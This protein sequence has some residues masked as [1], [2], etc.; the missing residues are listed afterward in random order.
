MPAK[1]TLKVEGVE[2]PVSNLQKVLYP[3]VGFTKGDLIDYYIRISPVML[4]HL[5]ARAITLKRYPEGVEGFFFYEK[6]C[7]S[8]R[9]KWLQTTDVDRSDGTEI[10]YCVVSSLPAL[11]WTVNLA[12]LEFHAFLHHAKS[13]NKPAVIAFDLDPGPP[14][15]ILDCCK[16]GLLVKRLFDAMGLQSFA[17]TS[18]SK[19]LQVYVPLNTPATYAKT[20]PFAQSVAQLLEQQYPDLVVSKMLKKLRVGKVLVDWSQNDD[21]KTTVNAYSTRAKEHPTVSTPVTWDEVETALKKKKPALLTFET[22]D[23]LKRVETLGDLFEPVLTLK[24]KL[25]PLKVL[26]SDKVKA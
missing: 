15:D 12:N 21:H 17:K 6:Q 26:S 5:K 10:N 2:V 11:V 24:Q 25:P 14:A 9:P 23:V 19:G 7:P 4:P 3:K 18:G 1:T 16:V 8:H 22:K 20:K 13:T